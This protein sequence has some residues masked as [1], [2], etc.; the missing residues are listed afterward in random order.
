M[1]PYRLKIAGLGRYLPRRVVPNAEV[2]ATLGLSAG[3]IA[4]T[5]A[6]VVARR[7]AADDETNSFMAAAAALEA[8]TAAG[9]EAGAVDLIIN[10]SGSAEQA[11]PDGGALV[12]RELGL[13]AS[14]IPAITLH[15]TC[16][17]F[18]N[19]LDVAGAFLAAG[20]YRAIL[21]VT[22]ELPSRALNPEDIESA[23]LFGDAAVAA[24]VVATPP[25][26]A[27]AIERVRFETY[28]EG[29]DYTR[30]LGGGTRRHPNDP[31]TTAADNLFEMQGRKVMAHATRVFPPFLARLGEDLARGEG[32]D[33]VVPHQPSALAL[34]I[35]DRFGFSRDRVGVTL[36]HLGNCGAASC[37]AT[38]YEL[39]ADG[40]V[41]RGD[42]LLLVGTG[43]GLGLGGLVMVY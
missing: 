11:V 2:E 38:L 37:P 16:L 40:R 4:R 42:R 32:V 24:V 14:G 1:L 5:Q 23:C 19:A 25:G 13:G 9:L 36:D 6:G 39:V 34:Q 22:S 33:W 29:A 17:S 21:I 26:E 12:Q 18:L 35:L 27:A 15:S 3:T 7:W 28:G 31:R 43:A 20:R 10:A 41:N 30:I 8:L